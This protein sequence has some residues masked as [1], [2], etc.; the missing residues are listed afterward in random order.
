MSRSRSSAEQRTVLHHVG[1]MCLAVI[2][3][4]VAWRVVRYLA[5]FPIWGDEAMLLVNLIERDYLGLTRPLRHEQVAPLLFLWVEKTALLAIGPAEQS[6]RLV[7]F[8]AGL[9]GLAG[10]LAFWRACRVGLPPAVAN[11]ALA[12]LAVSYYP[13]RHSVEVKPYALDLLLAATFIGLTLG[14]LRQQGTTRWL[15]ALTILAPVAMWWSYPA[16]FVAAASA[17]VLLPDMRSRPRRERGLYLLFLVLLCVSFFL[18]Y[19]LIGRE[20]ASGGANLA[21]SPFLADY[22]RN[23]FPPD[24]V[25]DWPFWLIKTFTGNMLAYPT[26]GKNGGSTLTFLLTVIGTIVLWRRA[27]EGA[28]DARSLL[29]LCWLPVAFTFAAAFLR[30]YPFGDSARVSLHMAPSIV[31]LMAIGLD[32]A[33]NW[34]RSQAWRS[35]WREGVFVSLLVFGAAGVARDVVTP[36]KTTHDRDVREL[37]R[38]ASRDVAAGE[39]M[40]VCHRPFEGIPAGLFWYIRTRPWDINWID[41]P[42]PEGAASLWVLQCGTRELAAADMLGCLGEQTDGWAVAE[43][44]V[45]VIPPAND[46]TPTLYCGWGRLVR[47]P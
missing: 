39:P 33:I 18:H 37:F 11:L 14:H 16:V 30:R 42:L 25:A 40:R 3:V 12:I 10:L 8:L 20:P 22:W 26:G 41:V 31:I 5:A 21:T 32:Q 23:A 28:R 1:T 2:A 35:R 7:P 4:G 34:S 44:H 43:R 15:T 19:G 47:A 9:A 6:V 17:V 46:V 38:D 45:R 27:R 29:A 13:I 36:Y 24:R